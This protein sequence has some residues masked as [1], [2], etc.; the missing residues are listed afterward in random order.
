MSDLGRRMVSM[1]EDDLPASVESGVDATASDA[2][3]AWGEVGQ[4]ALVGAVSGDSA[5][6]DPAGVDPVGV[7]PAGVDPASVDPVAIERLAREV[8][9]LPVWLGGGP[10]EGLS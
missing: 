2:P 3:S 9:A 4:D 6:V 5:G 1:F 8:L 10:L 7:D